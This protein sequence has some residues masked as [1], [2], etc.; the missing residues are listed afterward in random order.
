MVS[1][2]VNDRTAVYAGDADLIAVG[3]EIMYNPFWSPQAA[4]DLGID[5]GFVMW[6][7]QY[8]WW[9]ENRE[10]R[11]T[12]GPQTLNRP[13]VLN[14]PLTLNRREP[15]NEMIRVFWQPG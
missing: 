9:L 2:N 1:G 12:H 6:P 7:E 4:R 15:M 8:A 5:E 14:M 13:Q 11:F 10:R 3:R